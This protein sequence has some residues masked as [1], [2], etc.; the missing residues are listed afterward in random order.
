MA[1]TEGVSSTRA[2]ITGMATL[3]LP[4]GAALT[5]ERWAGAAARLGRMDRFCALALTA[6]DEALIDAQL[7]PTDA[8]A[9]DGDRT[10][11][12]V[13]SAYG[14]H[15]VNEDYYRGLLMHGPAGASPRAF[16]LTL[17]SSPLGEITIHYGLHGPGSTVVSG[18][19][20]GI[21]A[22]SVALAD[23]RSARAVRVLVVAV[24][25]STPLLDALVGGAP[26][27]VAAALVLELP[28]VAA[29]RGATP[30]GTL[31]SVA[32]AY[33]T[34]APAAAVQAATTQALLQSGRRAVEDE[35]PAA[36]MCD[37]AAGP[38]FAL[39]DALS[40][41]TDEP[42]SMMVSVSDTEGAAAAA[43]FD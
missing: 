4:R 16:A 33:S 29:A 2:V 7:S 14:C 38:L 19:V 1:L 15:A 5:R 23:L 39:I 36:P 8:A 34:A 28:E 18:L 12:G 10:A 31:A 30:R 41:A 6:V 27:D 3:R 24:D 9:W 13:G 20:A 22:L 40:R 43:V 17:P 32:L 35:L 11:V 42:R 26:Y 21:E 25:V 37:H